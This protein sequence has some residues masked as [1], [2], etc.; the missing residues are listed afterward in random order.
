[1]VQDAKGLNVTVALATA[2]PQR[3]G[4]ARHRDAVAQLIP[5][6]NDRIRAVG[7]QRRR[8]AHRRLRRDERRY[9]LI[10]VDDLHPTIRG[11][12]T[13]AGIFFEAI[14]RSLEVVSSEPRGSF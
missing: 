7:D 9:S 2:P 11:Y 5:S 12:D 13:M 6:F 1:M 14:K 10:G 8:A 4:G 3:A